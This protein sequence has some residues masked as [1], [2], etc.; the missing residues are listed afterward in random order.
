MAAALGAA[1]LAGIALSSPASAQAY[2]G[3][4]VGSAYPAY[5]DDY[6][7]A[8]A[9]WVA[10]QRWLAHERWERDEARRRWYWHE[11]WEHRRWD[12]GD[13]DDDD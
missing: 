12:H 2:F 3:F 11:Y 1:S 4:S 8:R 9:A 13:D 6:D 10:R 7:G 5:Y